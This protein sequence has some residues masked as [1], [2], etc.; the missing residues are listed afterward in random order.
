M[1]R[2]SVV[3][4]K[5]KDF[6]YDKLKDADNLN[7]YDNGDDMLEEESRP[8]QDMKP[9]MGKRD[10]EIYDNTYYIPNDKLRLLEIPM[11]SN[12]FF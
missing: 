7:T 2:E 10:H 11:N 4:N 9:K 1:G 5:T 12:L 8:Q 6:K 3:T